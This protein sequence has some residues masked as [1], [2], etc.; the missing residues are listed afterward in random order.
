MALLLL[1]VLSMSILLRVESHASSAGMAQLRAREAAR[2][3]LMLALG[4][5]QKHAGPDQRVTARAEILGSA[6]IA[7]EAALWTGVW[8][9]TNPTGEPVWL[10]SGTNPRPDGALPPLS[11]ITQKG[12]DQNND[13]LYTGMGD[14]GDMRVP[15]Q[16]HPELNMAHAWSISDEGVKAPVRINDAILNK[17]ANH[18]T[19]EQYLD[20]PL[21]SNRLLPL[22]IDEAFD[23]PELFDLEELSE[24]DKAL[25]KRTQSSRELG[26]LAEAL[27]SDAVDA[28]EAS[29]GESAI[30]ENYFVLSN[31]L[32]GGLKRDLSYLKTV[33]SNSYSTANIDQDYNDPDGLLTPDMVRL[34]QFKGN[35]TADP[36][37]AI[38]GMQL[39][40]DSVADIRAKTA[41]FSLSPVLTEFQLAGGIAADDEG[42]WRTADRD[43]ATDSAVYFVYKIYLEIWNPYTVPMRIGDPGLPAQLGYSDL[44]IEVGNLPSFTVTNLSTGTSISDEI[45]DIS[46]LWSDYAS[47]KIMRPG[48]VY[49]QTLPLDSA[50]DNDSGVIRRDLGVT[51]Q[52]SVADN[53]QGDFVMPAEPVTIS[54][55][56]IAPGETEK[57]ILRAEISNYPDYT[58]DYSSSNIRTRFKRRMDTS[59]SAV[60]GMTKASLEEAGYAFAFKFRMLDEQEVP[61]PAE[62]IS[63]LFSRFDFRNQEITVD[64]D[65]WD[66][67]NAWEPDNELP[68]DFF[69]NDEVAAP[70]YVD[71]GLFNPDESFRNI[72]F[73]RYGATS[74][75]Q[76]RI[77]RVFDL[78]V[79]ELTGISH[80]RALF[81]KN[82]GTNALGNKWG[83]D[84]NKLYDRYFFSSLADPDIYITQPDDVLANS[85]LRPMTEIP[86]LERPDAAQHFMLVNGFNLNSTSVAAWARVLGGKQIESSKFESR[87]ELADYLESPTWF[88][89]NNDFE[90]IFFNLPHSSLHNLVEREVNP[91]Y[92]LSTIAGAGSYQNYLESL[93]IDSLAWQSNLQFPAFFQPLREIPVTEITR[94]ATAIVSE[95]VSFTEG[96][97]RP[98]GS[99]A[100]F[101]NA[102][103]LENAINQVET[104]NNRSGDQD[105]IPGYTASHISQATLMNMI[106][107]KIFV[108]SDTFTIRAYAEIY[109]PITGIFE[110]SAACLAKVVRL[111]E[112]HE[113]PQMG[114]RFRILS[115]EWLTEL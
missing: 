50:G 101:L 100:E 66:I 110:G 59:N 33:D 8:D 69:L 90:N 28:I 19:E 40:E 39:F 54:I 115:F 78:P 6:N 2:F 18:P 17:L 36:G 96:N 3:A 41:D 60:G 29:T 64:L 43:T 95:I 102:G 68:Y 67:N 53:Y 91:R 104:I 85:H 46:M 89:I 16:Q 11:I 34:L 30:L 74:G 87:Y 1:L 25:L 71:P 27:G 26:L 98:P 15:L 106:G 56:G 12:Y 114:R 97:Q 88:D 38:I 76:D 65:N 70:D 61:G 105:A 109:D 72:D 42:L 5:L 47:S 83:G 92:N 112:E 45:S 82:Y 93:S 79:G 7:P 107:N 37:E 52:G 73:F 20:Y 75:R 111:P 57:E 99:I 84:L 48:M 31:T 23:Y 24:S 58:I 113:N 44:R 80:L 77:A 94:L 10:V 51:L 22:I 9:T 4:E 49:E 35:P 14:Y 103:I 21:L 63:R 86:T 55:Y 32:E 13:G 62:D 108:R 81:N